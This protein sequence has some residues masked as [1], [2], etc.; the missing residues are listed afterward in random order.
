MTTDDVIANR[1][2]TR[3]YIATRDGVLKPPCQD[4]YR[5]KAS[6]S[7]S[8]AATASASFAS[9]GSISISSQ[10]AITPQNAAAATE[11]EVTAASGSGRQRGGGGAGTLGGTNAFDEDDTDEIKYLRK[12]VSCSRKNFLLTF[13]FS[14]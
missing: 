1:V 12:P 11:K 13:F 2:L 8:S 14:F 3:V 7:L 5:V 9:S 6:A 10:Q 4:L